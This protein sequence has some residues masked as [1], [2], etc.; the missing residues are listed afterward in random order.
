MTTIEKR[1]TLPSEPPGS[2]GLPFLGEAIDFV[3][4]NPQ[5]F[6]KKRHQ[7]YG[8]IF[9]TSIFGQPTIF[10][11]GIEA[12]RFVLSNENVYFQNDMLPNMKTLIGSS[13]LT[14][15][16]ASIHKNRKQILQKLFSR[17]YLN[18]QTETIQAITQNYCQRWEKLGKFAWYYELQ[19]YSF[20]IAGKLFIGEDFA[21][22]SS[23]GNLYK[24][25]S[26]GLF[27]FSPNFPWTKLGRALR[28]REKILQQLEK[29]ISQRIKI[30]NI[31]R[32]QDALSLLL[33]AR[34]EDGNSLSSIE[35]K[36]Q[37]L[38]LLSAGHGTLA[39]A[40]TSFCLLLAKNPEILVKCRQEQQQLNLSSSLSLE[41]LQKMIYLEKV[42]KEV[43][44]KI[45][46]VGGGFRKVIRKCSF[47]ECLF[48]KDWQVIYQISLTHQEPSLFAF[49][50]T[51]DPER[52]NSINQDSV[53]SYIPFGGG[54]RRCLGENLAR[55]EM[56]IF[57]AILIREYDWEL[58]KNQNL[59]IVQTPFPHPRSGLKVNFKHI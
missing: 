30:N 17:Q 53:E 5:N 40:L 55:L 29:I 42:L 59:K 54:R 34:D 8:S 37:I 19:N 14:T 32:Y 10:V 31:D 24:I 22:S 52:F 58:T 23:L 33:Q 38:N 7:K 35:I 51:F 28:S 16:T 48:P 41:N 20:D 43:L 11:S 26:E 36:E 57:A 47:D 2:F 21:S 56:K 6:A 3:V 44:R 45:P 18:E 25:W 39:S 15:Q 27:S 46:P 49:A 1:N 13:A 50:D 9:K 12:C 4:S